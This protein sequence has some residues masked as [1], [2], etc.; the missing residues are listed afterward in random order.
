MVA[1]L[2]RIA[3]R[4]P[5]T[6]IVLA[7][8]IALFGGLSAASM[9]TD[10]FPD[11]DIPVVA[12]AWTYTG[13]SPDD[14]AG[15]VIYYYERTLSL[16]VN[17]I[18]HIESQ[19]LTGVGIVKIFF[20]PGVDIRTAT[21]QVTSVSQ[22]VLK[23]MPPGI[24]PPLIVNYSAATVPILQLGL[25]S[26]ELAEKDIFDFG[27]NF[28][29]PALASVQGAAVTSP[30]GG[31]IRQ[32]QVDL[33][34]EKLQA[35][36][37][38]AQDLEN[39][40][41]AQSQIIPAGTIKVGGFEYSVKLNN[42]PSIIDQLNDLPI[43]QV[44]GSTIY[45][46]DVGH[47][48]DGSPP[49]TNIVR[50]N[51][52]R[53]VLMTILKSGQTS[54][55]DIVN[56]VRALIPR[57]RQ[58]LPSSLKI[59]PLA[60]QSIFVRAA[61]SGVVREGVI[62]AALT[63]LMILLFLGSWRSTLIIVISIPLAIL[64]SLSLLSVMGQTLNLMTLGGLAL[65]VGILVD[66]ATV[67][68]ENINWHLEQG[69][70]VPQAILDGA[71]Q[72]VAPA[73]VSL[74]CIC[75]AFVPMFFLPGVSGYLFKPMAMAVVFALIGS[76]ILSRT[77]VNTLASYLLVA[78][79]DSK[80]VAV[81]RAHDAGKGH[82]PKN[83]LVRFQHGFEKRFESVRAAYHGYL[84]YAM[85]RR[86]RFA[87]GFVAFVLLSFLLVPFLGE[88]FFP[89][90]DAGAIALHVRAPVGTRIEETAALFDHVENRIRQVIPPSQLGAMVDNIGLPNSSTGTI[91][92]NT[93][94][95]GPEDGDILISLNENHAPTADYVKTLR[96]ALP[97]SFP[98]STFSFPPAD[99][100]SQV[101]NFGAP[102][103]I[104]VQVAGPD[105]TKDQAYAT[106]LRNRIVG[107]PGA[108]DV[109]LQQSSSYPTFGVDVDR[110]RAGQVGISERDVTN[111]MV[112]NLA[113]SVQVAP[114]YWLNPKNGV[115][116]P[117]VI[118]T[119]QYQLD[120]LEDLKNLPITSSTETT[121][122][123]LG[124]ISDIHREDT[125]AVVSHYAIQPAFDV[126]AATQDRDLGAVA[127]SIQRVLNQTEHDLPGGATVTIRGQVQT[128]NQAFSGLFF[129]LAEAV[130]LIYLLI[131]VNFHSWSDPFVIITA[132]PAALAGIVWTLF[133]T[134]TTLSVPALT[135]AIMCMGVATANSILV[136]SFARERLE[137]TGDAVKAAIEAG[138]TR[139]R[140]VLMTALAMIIGMAPMALGMGEGG[141]QNAPLGRA[142]IGGLIFAT[143]ATLFFV[144]AVFAM[145]RGRSA[146]GHSAHGP[147]LSGES[148]V[149]AE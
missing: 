99:M 143:F 111:S 141:E 60:D 124:G 65:A 44:N 127:S 149:P 11:I 42:T 133:A 53:G 110:T 117:I 22:T 37:L 81:A 147:L 101:L 90:V 68:I 14:M 2:I 105:F 135:G 27:Q 5:Y 91:Y 67:T 40:L 131:V 16:A 79:G 31:R 76:F 41:A 80:D 74:L 73:F 13:L 17:D 89:Q 69:K 118:Q 130:V 136:V 77:L 49:Q 19:S 129:G 119:P 36:H 38:S 83:P 70:S 86:G 100:V 137:A 55:L 126:Y 106:E 66:D 7:I 21:A 71:L 139:F 9:A 93:G 138:V 6:F 20:H 23:Q 28:I 24:T 1:A 26:D 132:L 64:F 59:V 114:T 104:D 128:M 95:L 72:I 146:H 3:L 54:T 46:R 62:A 125:N 45:F 134:H 82:H 57:L 84:T 10:I 92:S 87:I 109:R 85:E 98:G 122:Q 25:S 123:I 43:K 4:R 115:S 63:G 144:P 30:Y 78:H 140:P 52:R 48:Y 148:H 35:D 103:P 29:R 61:I 142:V 18:D 112:V 120:T 116:Y 56:N 94:T 12:V 32:V 96:A 75:I 58:T 145:V 50:M 113:G 47:V 8:V 121:P 108:V 88:N 102:A 97:Q 34:P 33:D 51:G 107:I 39:A 15:R